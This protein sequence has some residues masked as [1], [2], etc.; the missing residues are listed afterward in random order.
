VL[1]GGAAAAW[2]LSVRAQSGALPVIGFISGRSPASDGHLVQAFRK[3]LKQTGYV[4][5]RNV[6]IEF[7]WA[8]GKSE[9]LPGF[10][11]E[12]VA[13]HR[14]SAVF[15]GA[16][17]TRVH[18]LRPALASVPVVYALGGDPVLLGVAASLARPGGNATGMTV[19]TAALWPK[20]LALLHELIGRTERL[21]VLVDPANETAQSS[22]KDVEAAAKD[23]GQTIVLVNAKSEAEFEAA[24]A[25]MAQERAGALLVPDDP[26][27]INSRKLLVALATRHA[28]PALYGR[29]EFPADGGLASYGA[30]ADD[31]YYQ[32]GQ[33]VGRVLAGAKPGELP[34]LQPT[35][36]ELVI[37]LKAAKML[38]LSVP[39]TLFASADEVIE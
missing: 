18:E 30:S 27:F 29:R 21:A 4:E 23:I 11:A 3:G 28:I 5:G 12:L 7:R 15:A 1:V 25:R 24:F 38:G 14:V 9:R 20:R 39:T 33:Y 6:A 2:P 34:F 16:L 31:Q 37:N 26:V 8:E 36:F 32:C 22:T 13:G 35:K 19:M 10:A 17:D